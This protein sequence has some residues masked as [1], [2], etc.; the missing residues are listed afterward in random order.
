MS[1]NNRA[2]VRE[3]GGEG[4]REGRTKQKAALLMR[5]DNKGT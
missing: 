4:G 3:K 2:E 5:G 1:G